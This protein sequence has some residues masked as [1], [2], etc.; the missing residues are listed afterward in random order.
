M[1]PTQYRDYFNNIH[2]SHV[3]IA[4]FLYADLAKILS[5]QSDSYEYPLLI[6]E[7]PTVKFLENGTEQMRGA[8]IIIDR[9]DYGDRTDQ[10]DAQD[11]TYEIARDIIAKMRKDKKN[12]TLT[13]FEASEHELEP[14]DT[15]T[16]D[17]DIGWRYEFGIQDATGEGLCYNKDK[18]L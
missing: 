7:T 3:D 13:A 2:T 15:L 6:A 1:K 18:W 10:E 12:G 11:R 4:S 17:G 9:S 5:R 8:F 14:I 16:L